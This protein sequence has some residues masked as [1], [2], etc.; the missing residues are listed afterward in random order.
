MSIVDEAGRCLKCKKPMCREGCP[1]GTP[2]PEA[3]QLFL[4]GKTREAGRILFENNPLSAITSIVCPHENNC[5]KYCVLGRKGQP[6]EFSEVE[7]Y[8]SALYLDTFSM[9]PPESNGMMVAVIGSGPAGITVSLL[10]ALRGFKVTLIEA[11]DRIGG[12]LRYGIPEFRLPKTIVDKYAGILRDL[13]VK[14]KPNVFIGSRAT[15]EDLFIDGYKAVFV[16]VGTAKPIKFGL[17]GETLGHVHY[18]IDYLKSPDSYN[19]GKKV[20]IIGDGNVALDAARMAVRKNPGVSVTLVSRSIDEDMSGNRKEIEMAKV[21]GVKFMYLLSAVRFTEDKVIFVKVDMTEDEEGRRSYEESMTERMEIPAD[22]VIV[23]IGQGPQGAAVSE[24]DVD[25]T[26]RGLLDADESGRTNM[27]GV[28][29]AGD[30]VTGPRTV[31]EAV[32][33]SKNVADAIEQ[34]CMS[35]AK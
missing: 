9:K 24:S 18:A 15:L 11:Q 27:E 30:V 21:D 25:R 12:V 4:E 17:L 23:A 13:G 32:A 29:A 19:M 16:A 31:V 2:I 1:V 22:S 20:I 28:F 3:M 33:F 7:K 35:E 26:Q 14:F 5:L 6:I 8:I 10:L 34:Y